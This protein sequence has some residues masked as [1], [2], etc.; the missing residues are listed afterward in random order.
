MRLL[1]VAMLLLICTTSA[2]SQNPWRVTKSD[3]APM[4]LQMNAGYWQGWREEVL[5]HPNAFLRAHPNYNRE[6]WD[7]RISH[8][9]KGLSAIKDANHLLKSTVVL[10]QTVAIVIKVGDWRE[11]P[12]K[13]RVVKLLVDAIKYWGMYKLGFYLGYNIT[14]NNKL[15][16]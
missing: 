10:S 8:D 13:K 12:K 5:Y 15:R 11:Y 1:L 16:L 7:I 4:L 6:F 2:H 14:H 9:N 3:I